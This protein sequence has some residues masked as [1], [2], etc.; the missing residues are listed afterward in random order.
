MGSFSAI[1]RANAAISR[2]EADLAINR[3]QAIRRIEQK[4]VDTTQVEETRLTISA[5]ARKKYEED[6]LYIKFTRMAE[7]YESTVNECD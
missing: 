1:S 7:D 2:Y 5:A 6:L 3:V 4:H